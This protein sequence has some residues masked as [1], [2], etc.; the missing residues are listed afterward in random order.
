MPVAVIINPVAGGRRRGLPP[1]ARVA[2]ARRAFDRHRVDGRVELTARA[3]HGTDLARQAVADGC[4][5]VVAWGG[6][7]TINEVASV[8]MGA[9]VALGIVR[10]GS[11]NGLARE[12][13]IPRAPDAALEIA[14]GGRDRTID[15][16]EIEGHRFLNV[17]GIGFDAAMAMAFNALGTERRGRLRYTLSATRAAFT[18]QPA[19]YHIEADGQALDVEAL[20]VAIANLPQYGSNAVIAPGARPDDGRLDVVVIE[21]RGMLGRIGLVPRVFDRTIHKAPGV[22][23]LPARE[24]S[25]RCEGPMAFHVDGE[26]KPGGVLVRARVLPGALTVRVPR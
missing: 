18:Y 23:I 15:A 5:L 21:N 22:S 8:L 17:A 25:V 26:P 9:G 14:L 10:A 4:R 2:L 1:V 13:G 19:R 3:G 12:M 24:V 16:G 6:D 11:G 7:G 20:I